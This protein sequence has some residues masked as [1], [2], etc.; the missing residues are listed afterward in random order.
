MG[1]RGDVKG[2]LG[3]SWPLIRGVHAIISAAEWVLKL[4][5]QSA[6]FCRYDRSPWRNSSSMLLNPVTVSSHLCCDIHASPCSPA[7]RFIGHQRH[8]PEGEVQACSSARSQIGAIE[9][10][11]DRIGRREAS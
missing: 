6:I 8:I 5:G 4:A 9:A 2:L 11:G 7:E 10:L 1:G 3:K